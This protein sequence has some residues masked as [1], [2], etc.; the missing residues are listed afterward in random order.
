LTVTQQG[1]AGEESMKNSDNGWKNIL[2]KIKEIV[3]SA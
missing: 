1:Y 2:E 3:E